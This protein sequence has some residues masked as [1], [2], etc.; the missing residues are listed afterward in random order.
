MRP[1]LKLHGLSSALLEKPAR[2][3][4]RLRD[5]G[6]VAQKGQVSDHMGA[7][8]ASDDGLYVMDHLVHGHRHCGIVAQHHLAQAVSYQDQR[9]ACLLDKLGGC[10]VVRGNH[11]DLLPVPLHPAEVSDR[12]SHWYLLKLSEVRRLCP[13]YVCGLYSNTICLISSARSALSVPF[14]TAN[15]SPASASSQYSGRYS[16][17]LDFRASRCF[18]IVPMSPRG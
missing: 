13:D 9:D 8:G 12:N 3:A 10:V 1:P 15:G 4:D 16:G 17:A 11:G 2:V 6:V 18:L 14:S 5:I 7:L